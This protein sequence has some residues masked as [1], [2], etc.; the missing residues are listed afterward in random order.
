MDGIALKAA[1]RAGK[2]VYGTC[3]VSPSPLWPA[4]IAG[5]GLDFV[6]IDTPPSLGLLT[7]NALTASSSGVIIPVQCEYLALE[8]L[9]HLVQTINLI[10]Q[11]STT[12]PGTP[13]TP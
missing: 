11:L 3:V 7:V 9:S 8:G 4:M 6:F 1:L 12:P 10:Q 5:S 2:R 13:Q